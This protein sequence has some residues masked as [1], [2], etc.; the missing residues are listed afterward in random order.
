M[1]AHFECRASNADY[2][3]VPGTLNQRMLIIIDIDKMLSSE[4]MGLIG[5]IKAAVL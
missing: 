5:L 2:R 1:N 3:I 4:E